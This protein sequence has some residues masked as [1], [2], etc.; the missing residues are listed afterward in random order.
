MHSAPMSQKQSDKAVEGRENAVT[1][2]DD[3]EAADDALDTKIQS[4]QPHE[5][6][7]IDAPYWCTGGSDD[8]D[9]D[10]GDDDDRGEESEDENEERG[11][12]GGA[13]GEQPKTVS[14]SQKPASE[15]PSHKWI[16]MW[17]SWTLLTDY[18]RFATYTNP[19]LFDMHIYSDFHWFVDP[20]LN[21]N[22]LPSAYPCFRYGVAELIENLLAKF[23]EATKMHTKVKDTTALYDMWA[24]MA[25]LG[26][27]IS[28][29]DGAGFTLM[30][31]GER[32]DK[33]I[34]LIGCAFLTMLHSLLREKELKADSRF[35]DLGL[36]IS[37]FLKWSDGQEH[38]EIPEDELILAY[39]KKAGIDLRATGCDDIGEIL[40]EHEGGNAKLPSTSK[41]D[42]YGW[43]KTL[44]AY[45]ADHTQHGEL[46]GESYNILKMSR[47]DRA[48]R[49]FDK[50]DP[51]A[52]VS[53]KDLWEGNIVVG[54]ITSIL[55]PVFA[56]YKALRTSDPA[57]L[58]PWL[59]YWTTLSLFLLIESQLYFILYW[60]PFYP[61]IRFALHLYLVL[62]GKQGSVF[63]YK[64]YIHPFLEE[65]ERQID[66][67]ISEGHA[68]ARAAGLDVVKR[69]IEYIRVQMLGQAP[70]QPTPPQSRSVSYSTYLIDRFAMPSARQGMG[71][72]AG[73]GDLFGL[74]GKALQQS[75]YPDASRD[76]QARDLASS[77]TL[78]PPSLSGDDRETYVNTQ[79]ERLRTLL[80]AFDTEAFNADSATSGAQ[81]RS[82][83]PQRPS[84]RKSYLA[85][86]DPG[87]MHK[88]RSESE[89]EDLG[90]E[91]M[92]DP[93]QYRMR[94]DG[95]ERSRPS[96]SAQKPAKDNPGWSNW[97]WGTY[98]DKDSAVSSKKDL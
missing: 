37:L 2:P 59:M 91:T 24:P 75:T 74:L 98:G 58:T 69:G 73:T 36:V 33:L 89:F 64:E 60:I 54:S 34:G 51:L 4:K 77:G 47:K 43:A 84:S 39:A 55:F 90:Y 1:K 11:E 28:R 21:G 48:R 14:M 44:K 50:K 8:D 62:P 76:D 65:H 41:K 93:E 80:Q 70:K 83:M 63:L 38:N 96:S 94:D 81:T 29:E 35:R 53:D 18:M 25:T 42:P 79:R 7:C 13:K 32:S 3:A 66:R 6:I 56:S 49:A 40:E 97:I 86:Q 72:V 23:E 20:Y 46:G 82:S 9:D 17:Q 22:Q 92:P 88:S 52:G 57:V 45:K 15:H 95:E 10:A 26:H 19:G 85:P 78:V 27:F 71:T 67:T 68:K 16:V 5:Y 31:D 12:G 61:W 30:D 87:Y